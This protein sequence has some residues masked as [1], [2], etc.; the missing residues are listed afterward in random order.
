MPPRS[1]TTRGA[2]KKATPQE[3]E[4][5]ARQAVWTNEMSMI[6]TEL[7]ETK[8]AL[9][10]A[11]AAKGKLL[12]VADGEKLQTQIKLHETMRSQA[13][14]EA[15][16][17]L[18]KC[19]AMALELATERAKCIALHEA[20]MRDRDSAGKLRLVLAPLMALVG[21]IYPELLPQVAAAGMPANAI[22]ELVMDTTTPSV[23]PGAPAAAAAP[24]PATP[25]AAA[26]VPSQILESDSIATKEANAEVEQVLLAA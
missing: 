5:R 1:P 11:L 15:R 4:Q 21:D 7:D 8:M 12:S 25:K 3:L 18:K 10:D 26:P 22:P 17:A 19:S 13:V 23:Q 2:G 14:E 16:D 6:D 9:A 20:A 24:V